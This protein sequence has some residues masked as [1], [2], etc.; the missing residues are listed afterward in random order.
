MIYLKSCHIVIIHSSLDEHL[1]CF[2]FLD[3]VNISALDMDEQ[4]SL[5]VY[6]VSYGLYISYGLY[7]QQ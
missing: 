3:I 2:H 7:A 1:S 4:V 5:I 6:M